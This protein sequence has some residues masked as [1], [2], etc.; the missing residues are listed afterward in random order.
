[1]VALAL[2]L[3]LAVAGMAADP[4]DA[5][6]PTRSAPKQTA[7]G[8]RTG[9][10][11]DGL[12]LDIGQVDVL[13]S[14]VY[15]YTFTTAP[16]DWVPRAGTWKQTNRWDCSPQWTWYGGY[17]ID[18]LAA[19]WNKHQFVGDLTVEIYAAMKMGVGADS[20]YK[21]PN[22]MNL[23]IHG[24]GANLDSGYSFVMGGE[25]NSFSRIMKGDQVL[26]ETRDVGALFPIF[27]DAWPKDNNDFHRKWWGLRA[28]L[29]GNRLQFYKDEK[30]ILEAEDPD[31]LPGGRVAL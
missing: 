6:V 22:D 28:R 3:C 5:V 2:L 12:A 1:M 17:D 20:R 29:S 19:T 13:S 31:P 15:D 21:N 25:L 11:V 14:N 16:T 18:G 10:S 4:K 26:A 23:T 7:H 24:D 9:V 8:L 27:E 30:L